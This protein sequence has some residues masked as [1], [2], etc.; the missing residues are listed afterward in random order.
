MSETRFTPGPWAFG[1]RS[2]WEVYSKSGGEAICT[3]TAA[4][5]WQD[6]L[7]DVKHER[8]IAEANARLIAAAPTL[9]EAAK[10]CLEE[11]HQGCSSAVDVK[12][13]EAAIAKAEGRE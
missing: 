9:L 13:L 1:W 11:W 2:S 3:V 10:K 6:G 7:L 8:G 5:P 4:E 12:R